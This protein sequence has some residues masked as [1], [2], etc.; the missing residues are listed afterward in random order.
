MNKSTL[1]FF[2]IKILVGLF[3]FATVANAANECSLLQPEE[4]SEAVIDFYQKSVAAC[5][6]LKTLCLLSPA[7]NYCA[8]KTSATNL[9]QNS[10]I[11]DAENEFLDA[12]HMLTN[13]AFNFELRKTTGSDQLITVSDENRALYINKLKY[14]DSLSRQKNSLVESFVSLATF[15]LT[16]KWIDTF[17][18]PYKL[19]PKG[20]DAFTGTKALDLN[21]EQKDQDEAQLNVKAMAAMALISLSDINDLRTRAITKGTKYLIAGFRTRVPVELIVNTVNVGIEVAS[22]SLPAVT[23]HIAQKPTDKLQERFDKIVP[24]PAHIIRYEFVKDFDRAELNI[25]AAWTQKE[26]ELYHNAM[27][28]SVS[29]GVANFAGYLGNKYFLQNKSLFLRLFATSAAQ[30][31]YIAGKIWKGLHIT[32]AGVALG[33]YIDSKLEEAFLNWRLTNRTMDLE[34]AAQQNNTKEIYNAISHVRLLLAKQ[35][36]DVELIINA[37][38]ALENYSKLKTL[39]PTEEAVILK[40]SEFIKYLH[41]NADPE[42]TGAKILGNTICEIMS[43]LPNPS[44]ASLLSKTEREHIEKKEKGLRQVR[45]LKYYKLI[46]DKLEGFVTQSRSIDEYLNVETYRLE[47]LGKKNVA[48]QLTSAFTKYNDIK[49]KS[50]RYLKLMSESFWSDNPNF[51]FISDQFLNVTRIEWRLQNPNLKDF[52]Y[53]KAQ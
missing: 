20:D 35:T 43:E 14:L 8:D 51:Q 17:G 21:Q 42:L 32:P 37:L 6:A 25:E 28:N 34:E 22:T 19:L 7:H 47:K 13:N 23:T 41:P 44:Q 33:F 49:R 31:K 24:S 45:L 40:R 36:H 12:L 53:C 16:L 38:D 18:S 9:G 48:E 2:A 39:N 27:S 11:K 5:S 3:A 50:D 26:F 46:K 10:E 30:G 52:Y 1:I 4:T 15:S 29:V